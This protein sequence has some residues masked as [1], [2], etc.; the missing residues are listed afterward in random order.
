MYV[1]AMFMTGWATMLAWGAFRP[2]ERRGLLP[3]TAIMLL[4][5]VGIELV[6]YADT[7]GG[8]GFIFGVTKR[9]V[10]SVLALAA[11]LFSYRING[12]RVKC[13]SNPISN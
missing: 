12:V 1:S 7:L 13:Q 6:F 11:Y 3:V 10:L 5:S 4:L 9:I 2:V 8:G